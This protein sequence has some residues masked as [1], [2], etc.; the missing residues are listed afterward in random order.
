MNKLAEN[1]KWLLKNANLS[2]NE[3]SRRTNIPQQIINRIIAGKNKNPKLE[4]IM[5]IA[6]YFT[7]SISQLI[8]DEISGE[9]R[10]AT[11]HFG[12][13]EIPLIDLTKSS[14]LSITELT[15]NAASTIKADASVSGEGIAIKM[16]DDSMQPRF[17][18]GTILIFDL[19]KSYKNG[20][21]CLIY[22]KSQQKQYLFR[23]ILIKNG[24]L[25]T[26]CINPKSSY[27]EAKSLH[28][29]DEIIGVL[30]QARVDF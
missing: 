23:Q 15:S 10:L 21:F 2:E 1:L 8:G 3:L 17:P 26:K 22:S 28:P 27:Y 5:P 7:V 24:N 12:W 13:R 14:S 20:K 18:K 4:T 11:E 16:H 9:I 6:S 19:N 25:F 30:V 29:K